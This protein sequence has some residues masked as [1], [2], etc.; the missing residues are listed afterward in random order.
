MT[1][2][3]STSNSITIKGNIIKTNVISSGSHYGISLADADI[4]YA[5][6]YNNIIYDF[7]IS[8]G[9]FAYGIFNN[10]PSST[11]IYNNTV[12]NCNY[13]IFINAGTSIAKNN[14]VK[15]SGNANAY[16]NVFA[17]GTD[18]NAT[19]GTDDIGT[20][21]HNK[22]SQTFSF[23]D[24]SNDDFHLSPT[25]T[26]AQNSGIDIRTDSNL[27]FETDIDG[28]SRPNGIWD[29]GADETSGVLRIDGGVRIKGGVKI[30]AN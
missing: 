3:S 17:S 8:G 22:I 30:D 4:S 25:D 29:I 16:V 15:G 26:A 6:V 24:E 23:V 20:G 9:G 19:D 18:Y 12:Q 21:T 13:G 11:L 5:K 27:S 7:N 2:I 1:A 10:G 28:N 14:I